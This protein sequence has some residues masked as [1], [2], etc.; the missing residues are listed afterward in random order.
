MRRLTI[1]GSISIA[2]LVTAV[3]IANFINPGTTVYGVV[4]DNITGAAVYGA[5]ISLKGKIQKTFFSPGFKFT[6]LES[7]TATLNIQAVGY[8][9]CS[10][11]VRIGRGLTTLEPISLKAFEIPD[12]SKSFIF[13]RNLN[14]KSFFEIRLADSRN[15]GIIN[16]PGMRLRLLARIYPQIGV[17]EKAHVIN[18]EI[19]WQ[20]ILSV[21]WNGNK[22]LGHK[23]YAPIDYTAIDFKN[24]KY[25]FVE[26]L[27]LIPADENITEEEMD[28]FA[29]S[30]IKLN[31]EDKI[32]E[33]LEGNSSKARALFDTISDLEVP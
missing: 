32:E 22:Y 31:S 16:P 8:K 20:G 13:P 19:L 29:E 12:L 15:R 14:E 17:K 27:L 18:S 26:C 28:H 25:A 21:K 1:Y 33:F 2:L 24:Y 30:I 3:A 5:E 10:R 11:E 6:N 4:I 7:G 9:P 23:Y